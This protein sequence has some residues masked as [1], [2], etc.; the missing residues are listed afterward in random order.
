MPTR[1]TQRAVEREPF[2]RKDPATGRVKQRAI[3]DEGQPGLYV[4]IGQRTKTYMVKADIYSPAPDPAT[5]KR[6]L[7]GTKREKIGD[8][9]TMLPDD[10]RRLA[11]AKLDA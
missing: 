9:L 7:A 8:A 10:A 3:F 6:R 11:R 4:L 2:A 1:L 5:G